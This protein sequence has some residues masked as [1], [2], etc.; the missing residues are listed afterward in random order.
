MT[1]TPPA[2]RRPDVVDLLAAAAAEI[3]PVDGPAATAELLVAVAHATRDWEVWGGSR[4]LEYWDRL[5]ERVKVA[6]YRGPTLGHWWSAIA[7]QLGCSQ[8]ARK[9]D[10]Q[11]LAAALAC[12]QDSPVLAALRA[13][14]EE[15]VLRV[16][17]AHDLHR[18]TNKPGTPDTDTD[19]QEQMFA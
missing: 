1:A 16:R 18:Q 9:E 3:G 14:P 15:L 5:P 11:A 4:A 17:L 19:T 2:P 7:R 6:T 8:P 10:R 13:R 12:G